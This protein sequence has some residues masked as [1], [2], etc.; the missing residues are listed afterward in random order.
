MADRSGQRWLGAAL[1]A[2]SAAGFGAMAIFTRF[3]YAHGADLYGVLIPRF[4]LAGIVLAGLVIAGGRRLPPARQVLGLAAMGGIGYVGQSFCYFSA[5][6]Y[7]QASLVALLLYLFPFFVL[8][9]AALFL[10]ERITW[11][12]AAALAVCMLGTALTIG[13]GKG[14]PLGIAFGV[15]AAVLYSLYIVAGARI[16]RGVDPLVSTM[17]VCLSAAAVFT[18]VAALRGLG[19]TPPRFPADALGWAMAGAI[20][21]ISTVLAILCFFAGLARLGAARASMLSTLEPVV[22]VGLAALFLG[23]AMTSVQLVGG[24]LILAAVLALARAEEGP[25][26][27]PA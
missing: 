23:E 2:L 15:A 26:A 14:A 25:S 10:G 12:K 19:G 5:L 3:A 9:L 4:W 24:A 6:Q 17:I 20:A 27:G 21:L 1:I 16:T 13:G 18:A 8:V 11:A 7:A 22:T